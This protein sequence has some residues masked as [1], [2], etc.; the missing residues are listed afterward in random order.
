MTSPMCHHLPSPGFPGQ[1]EKETGKP[2]R[3]NVFCLLAVLVAGFL[4]VPAMGHALSLTGV[5]AEAQKVYEK[6]EDLQADFIQETTVKSI[7]RTDREEGVFYFRKPRRTVWAYVK[8]K[9]KRLVINP[10][11]A[12]LYIPEDK[13]VYVQ[14]AVEIF[15]TKAIIRFLSGWGKLTEDFDITFTTPGGLDKGGNFLLH[16]VPKEKGFG[17]EAFSLTLSKTTFQIIGMQFT[18]SYGNE[19]RL[20]FR[21]IKIN[22]HLSDSFF[23][24]VPPEGVEV[25]N[26]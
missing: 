3:R 6:T 11:K 14:D 17:V 23:N 21:N 15:K 4:A 13:A 10:Q 16:L 5:I 8:P 9:D 20:T 18:D 2:C 26:N 7:N 25:Y 12:W 24:F 1:R 22:N 19:T